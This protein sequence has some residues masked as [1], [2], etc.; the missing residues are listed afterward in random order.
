[1]PA[2]RPEPPKSHNIYYAVDTPVVYY[3]S[4]VEEWL[5]TAEAADLPT[6]PQW[7]SLVD[8]GPA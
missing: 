4:M 7:Q 8:H 3:F 1:M 2:N 6:H 5:T